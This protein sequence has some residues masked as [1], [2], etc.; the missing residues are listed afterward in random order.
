MLAGRCRSS[1]QS[2]THYEAPWGTLGCWGDDIIA[3]AEDKDLDALEEH[4]KR[5]IDVKV[6]PRLG[7]ESSKEVSFLKRTLRYDAARA[8]IILE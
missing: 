4:L 2:C 7:G 6:L 5:E 1:S 3:E 8:E